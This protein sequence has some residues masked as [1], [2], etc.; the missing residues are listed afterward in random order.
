MKSLLITLTFIFNSCTVYYYSIDIYQ[1]R[2]YKNKYT[3]FYEPVDNI[4]EIISE[5][6]I[7]QQK[8]RIVFKDKDKKYRIIFNKSEENENFIVINFKD[9]T[10]FQ[11]SIIKNGDEL[12]LKEKLEIINDYD[13]WK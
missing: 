5:G 6:K 9:N 4:Y 7:S 10:L 12:V 3:L 8:N 11:D 13:I 2:V 1:V